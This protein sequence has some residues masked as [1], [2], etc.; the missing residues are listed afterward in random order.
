MSLLQNAK[1]LRINQTDAEQLVWRHIRAER[2]EGYKFK[3]Q[4]PIDR[5]IVDFVCLEKR[6]IVDLDGGQQ[7]GSEAD[8]VRDEKLIELG[9]KVVRFWNNDVLTKLEG[10]LNTVLAGLES[11]LSSSLPEGRED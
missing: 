7:N 3:R 11:P 9:F 5:Y 10:V 2:L 6:L 4:V 1:F 8:K